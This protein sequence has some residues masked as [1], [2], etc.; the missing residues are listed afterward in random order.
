MPQPIYENPKFSISRRIASA[1][2]R[3]FSVTE[4]FALGYRNREDNTKLPPGVLIDG[5][6]NVLTDVFNRVGIT[7]G[8]TRDGQT[9]DQNFLLWEDEVAGQG[10]LLLEDG[11]KII[12][13]F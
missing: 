10:F 5:S 4:N 1:K 13:N 2:V 9:P 12:L 7:K 3:E 11:G 8:Y 6:Q